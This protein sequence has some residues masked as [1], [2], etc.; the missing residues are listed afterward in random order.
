M[1]IL[2]RRRVLIAVIGL[3]AALMIAVPTTAFAYWVVT[4]STTGRAQSS[5]FAISGTS[6]ASVQLGG[7]ST[8]LEGFAGSKQTSGT[9][10]NT[11]SVSWASVDVAASSS[12][13]FAAP[14]VVTLSVALTAPTAGCPSPSSGVYTPVPA[15]G[16]VNIATPAAQ[17]APGASVKLCANVAYSRLTIANRDTTMKAQVTIAPRLHNWTAAPSTTTLSVTAPSA[18]ALKC[19]ADGTSASV[20]LVSPSTGSYRLAFR[21]NGIGTA[22]YVVSDASAV[23]ELSNWDI[24]WWTT[25]TVSIQRQDGSTWV[26]VAEGVISQGFWGGLTCR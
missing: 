7:D 4:A 5:T 2:S 12:S 22:K 1:R 13:A 3:V 25:N 8:N 21:G 9:I 16:T 11:G 10:T 24:G 18:G 6:I 23:F 15:S 26:T 19:D 17:L 20:A 14:A